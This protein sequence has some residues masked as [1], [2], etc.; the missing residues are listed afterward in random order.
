MPRETAKAKAA[1]LAREKAADTAPPASAA[2]PPAAPPPNGMTSQQIE[3]LNQITMTRP[4]LVP[5]ASGPKVEASVAGGKVVVGCKVGLA[6][7][8]LQLCTKV[9]VT[10]Q[11]TAGPREVPEY[12]RI[13]GVVQIRGTAYPRGTPP[14]GFPDRPKMAAGCAFTEEVDRDFMVN[15]MK[16]NER[17]PMVENKM[18]FIAEDLPRAMAMAAELETTRSGFEPLTVVAKDPR[19]ARNANST[20]AAVSGV[21][22]ED[23]RRG[24]MPAA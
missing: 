16:Q 4:D 2:P 5:A 10:E 19:V 20:N 3:A 12:R 15:W 21:E 23:S 22:T 8:N 18:V 6:L 11:T 14:I 1:R 13:G 7:V 17:N 9:M 24:K